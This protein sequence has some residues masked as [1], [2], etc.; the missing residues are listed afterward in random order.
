MA[1]KRAEKKLDQYYSRRNERLSEDRALFESRQDWL[2]S[3]WDGVDLDVYKMFYQIWCEPIEGCTA[4]DCTVQME[5]LPLQRLLEARIVTESETRTKLLPEGLLAEKS[6]PW[7]KATFSTGQEYYWDG[8]FDVP[9][10][11][12]YITAKYWAETFKMH[13]Q[14]IF[15]DP[16]RD[17]KSVDR[18]FVAGWRLIK[19]AVCN[20]ADDRWRV[21]I[22]NQNVAASSISGR[23]RHSFEIELYKHSFVKVSTE[24]A[25]AIHKGIK[26][27]DLR[28]LSAAFQFFGTS[29]EFRQFRLEILKQP[30]RLSPELQQR[31]ID[32][33]MSPKE[34]GDFI[35]KHYPSLADHYF[36][37]M[38]GRLREWLSRILTRDNLR[39]IGWTY[40]TGE[41]EEGVSHR[42]KG[43]FDVRRHEVYRLRSHDL[44]PGFEIA[45]RTEAQWP[46]EAHA[47]SLE[48][49]GR[50][51]L[52]A[53]ERYFWSFQK[54]KMMEAS[55]PSSF[56]GLRRGSGISRKALTVV[57]PLVPTLTTH[58]RRFSMTVVEVPQLLIDIDMEKRRRVDNRKTEW[59]VS[60]VFILGEE[61]EALC[62]DMEV[63]LRPQMFELHEIL[64]SSAHGVQELPKWCSNRAVLNEVDRG[65]EILGF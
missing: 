37:T 54:R 6:T 29:L 28:V 31:I 49:A 48:R 19:K 17:W 13:L 56:E 60:T 18:Q 57:T 42:P 59:V 45:S 30:S 24:W 3:I 15:H 47:S 10:G 53:I 22:I 65:A 40:L 2:C 39:Y 7:P 64:T 36:R 63:F 26:L 33:I 46:I 8:R 38:S 9:D 21:E 32:A 4:Q 62:N 1:R 58:N 23:V 35:R 20:P 27:I 50:M 16:R 52:L 51:L 11:A 5:C 61:L 34:T 25:E 43:L 55:C 12:S 41:G 44:N 14:P